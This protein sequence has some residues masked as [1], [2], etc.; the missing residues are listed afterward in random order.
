M[1]ACMHTYIHAY[2]CVS[3][4]IVTDM[5]YDYY[6]FG[7]DSLQVVTSPLLIPY[8]PTNIAQIHVFGGTASNMKMLGMPP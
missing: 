8:F 3:G 7:S 6:A 2:T 1:H 5:N 4:H